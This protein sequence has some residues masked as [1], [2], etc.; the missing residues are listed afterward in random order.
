M[1]NISTR[2]QLYVYDLS[3][4]LAR[5]LSRQLTGRQI[6]GIWHTSVVA[7]GKEHF[8]GHGINV[9]APGRSHHGAPLHVMDMGETS[10]DEETFTD[11]INDLGTHFTADNVHFN[12]N[13]FTNDV[14]GFLTGN[15]I[16][17]FIKDLP[18]DF[19][20][21]PFGASLRPTIDAMYRRPSPGAP[22]VTAPAA[23]ATPDPQLTASIL[24]SVAAQAQS[25]ARMSNGAHAATNS[26]TS[27]VHVITNP[28]SFQS[29]LASHKA[30]AVFFTS[31]T[32][33]P[34]RM[35]EPMFERLAQEKGLRT[36]GRG[37]K[38]VE[39]Y[40]AGFAK[41]DIGIGLGQSLASQF[42]VRVTPT[43]MFFVSGQKIQEIKGADAAE[44]R[45]QVDL[46][47][48]QVYPP[49]P[50]TK[51]SL[52]TIQKLTFDPIL[53]TQTPAFDAL[54]TKLSSFIDSAN[55]PPTTQTKDQ[56]K[57][58]IRETVVPYLKTR[59]ASN[60]SNHN[61]TNKA[62][63]QPV[64]TAWAQASMTLLGVLPLQNLFPVVDLWRLFVLDSSVVPWITS[65]PNF[66]E[67][68]LTKLLTSVVGVVEKEGIAAPSLRNYV[69]TSLRLFANVFASRAVAER[70]LGDEKRRKMMTTLVVQT[71]LYEDTGVKSASAALAFNVAAVLQR[72]RVSWLRGESVVG[73]GEDVEIENSEEWEVEMVSAVVEA[74]SREKENEDFVHRLTASLTFL[75]RLSPY[76]E[77]I[78]VLLSVL[79]CSD[80][81]RSKLVK[82]EGW[83]GDGGIKKDAVRKLMREAAELVQ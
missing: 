12:C 32:C 22:P 23:P 41:V 14:V 76:W 60:T 11:Y 17:D 30:A 44:L 59:F 1:A 26:L 48:F 61:N 58:M 77:S 25:G 64:L 73:G 67:H 4:G 51:L 13:S 81:L 18:T 40:G 50:H 69:L 16:P 24:Q 47:L 70:L 49:H 29:F 19:L 34:C 38:L 79:Q 21:T 9:T 55:W 80:I 68:P 56:V 75:V 27:P 42:G 36:R 39:T 45:T 37:G 62:A 43:F 15:S 31:Q 82:G 46:M 7:F 28:A 65:Y 20:S 35:I 78:K 2:V 83:N 53:F 63:A 8:Y 72:A 54:A 10:I 33:G 3:N 74:L 66:D 57:G 5:Q 71:L 6:D 52:H